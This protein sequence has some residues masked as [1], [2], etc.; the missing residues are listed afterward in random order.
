MKGSLK[1]DGSFRRATSRRTGGP[2]TSGAFSLCGFAALYQSH[3]QSCGP[4]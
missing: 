2:L 3:I 1:R 4:P